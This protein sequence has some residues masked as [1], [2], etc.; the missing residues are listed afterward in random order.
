[1]ERLRADH[2]IDA[3]IGQG[4][5]F[6]AAC[7]RLHGWQRN[8]Q[9]RAHLRH[10]LHRDHGGAGFGQPARELAGAGAQV[11]HYA[12]RAEAQRG[13]QPVIDGCGIFGASARVG[14]GLAGKSLRGGSVDGGHGGSGWLAGAVGYA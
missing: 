8:G 4:D 7:Q 3:G 6:G 13:A 12:A 11:Q 14:I 10:R 5:R 2:G 1:M 9:L